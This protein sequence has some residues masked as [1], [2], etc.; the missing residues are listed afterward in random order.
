[1]TTHTHP[2]ERPA[3]HIAQRIQRLRIRLGLSQHA[4]AHA[5]GLTQTQLSATERARRQLTTTNLHAIARGLR[6]P[7][8]RLIAEGTDAAADGH[9]QD[10]G[11]AG[12]LAAT[13][14]PEQALRLARALERTATTRHTQIVE[15]AE[16]IAERTP[17]ADAHTR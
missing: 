4:L 11:L 7:I 6:I 12:G 14:G 3:L 16:F 5:A 13:L 1:M 15:F 9:A 10:A 8:E 17:V 2:L